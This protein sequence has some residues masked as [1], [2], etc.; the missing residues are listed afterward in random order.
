MR[1]TSTERTLDEADVFTD[2]VLADDELVREEFDALIAACWEAPCE[3]PTRMPGPAAGPWA[4]RPPRRWPRRVG[5]RHSR[6]PRRRPHSRQRGP[7][8]ERSNC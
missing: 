6:V 1:A 5:F 4:W 3:P 2:L 8:R 7:P